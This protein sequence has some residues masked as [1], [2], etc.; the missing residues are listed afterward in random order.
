M[1][2]AIEAFLCPDKF[3]KSCR[4]PDSTHNRGPVLPVLHSLRLRYTGQRQGVG[5]DASLAPGRERIG[6][7]AKNAALATETWVPAVSALVLEVGHSDQKVQER[8]AEQEPIFGSQHNAE[9]MSDDVRA[10]A[11]RI[12]DDCTVWFLMV[13]WSNDGEGRS[14]CRAERLTVT[15]RIWLRR[16][17][18][19]YSTL[20]VVSCI[21]QKLL[22]LRQVRYRC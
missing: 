21:C 20:T 16:C 7:A 19:K 14:I 2:V 13:A 15:A 9:Q 17:S 6:R 1:K 3:P 8:A 18:A 12:R 22:C 11:G 10:V 5:E 4:L